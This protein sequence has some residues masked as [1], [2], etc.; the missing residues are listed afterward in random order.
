MSQRDF[1]IEYYLLRRTLRKISISNWKGHL[2]IPYIIPKNGWLYGHDLIGKSPYS[3][4][5]LQTPLS[6]GN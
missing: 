5:K 4:K 6:S 2:S 1:S 3:G